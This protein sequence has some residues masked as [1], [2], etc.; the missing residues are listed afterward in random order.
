MQV[1][2]KIGM[3]YKKTKFHRKN[4]NLSNMCTQMCTQKGGYYNEENR[5]FI[6]ELY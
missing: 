3:W 4:V 1:F 5:R 6:P 2:P